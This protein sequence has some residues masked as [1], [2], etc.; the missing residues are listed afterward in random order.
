MGDENMLQVAEIC[1][2][3]K[4][5]SGHA[6]GYE[7]PIN[8]QG[9]GISGGQRQSITLARTLF[10]NRNILLLD[11]PTSAM[12]INAEAEILKKMQAYC[13]DK[14]LLLVTHRIKL[15]ELVDRV[16]VIEDGV[17]KYDGPKK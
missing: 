2:I 1:G 16:I 6:G 15:L 13:K 5:I 14:T 12:D 7:M 10:P 3:D 9:S 17:I 4:L 11:E 8:E